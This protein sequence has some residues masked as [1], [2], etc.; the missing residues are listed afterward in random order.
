MFT[1]QELLCS[2][3]RQRQGPDYMTGHSCPCYRNKILPR[4]I[5]IM[6]LFYFFSFISDKCSSLDCSSS[7]YRF[8][9]CALPGA[10]IITRITVARKYSKSPCNYGHSYGPGSGSIWVNRGCRARFN[11]CYERRKKRK[12][13]KGVREITFTSQ[14]MPTLKEIISHTD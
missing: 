14:V 1:K 3:L 10:E 13:S 11:V 4:R 8:A 5:L 9:S 7:H 6:L 12:N 2:N